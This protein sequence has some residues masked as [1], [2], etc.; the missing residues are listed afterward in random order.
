MRYGRTLPSPQG[1]CGGICRRSEPKPAFFGEAILEFSLRQALDKSRSM[2]IM[3]RHVA[4]YAASMAR[5]G[6]KVITST[7]FS[8]KL[9]RRHV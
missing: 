5:E 6:R 7:F 4:A 3:T 9:F 2:H 1:R 8:G